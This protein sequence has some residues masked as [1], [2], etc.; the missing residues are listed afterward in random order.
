MWVTKSNN[1]D[2]WSKAGNTS[3]QQSNQQQP[4]AVWRKIERQ[5]V[6]LFQ[7]IWLKKYTEV[8]RKVRDLRRNW[9]PRR[10]V[11]QQSVQHFVHGRRENGVPPF[12][13]LIWLTDNIFWVHE[14]SATP[15][16]RRD[17]SIKSRDRTR[18]DTPSGRESSLVSRRHPPTIRSCR[19]QIPNC[20]LLWQ[21]CRPD[22]RKFRSDGQQS[23]KFHRTAAGRL[24]GKSKLLFLLDRQLRDSY[25]SAQDATFFTRKD[26]LR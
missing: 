12:R 21:S 10:G 4:L 15:T 11:V 17:P 14:L 13:R 5:P 6:C 3:F 20:L 2:Y 25:R 22:Q 16:L 9:R 1:N 7:K 18:R 8:S 26:V 19:S 24:P 23:S